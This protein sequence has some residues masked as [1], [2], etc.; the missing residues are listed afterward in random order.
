MVKIKL[1]MLFS[2]LLIMQTVVSGTFRYKPPNNGS[3]KFVYCINSFKKGTLKDSITN[4]GL[5]ALISQ[6]RNTVL[7]KY[8]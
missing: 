2:R 1:Y 7:N 6:K 4:L 3:Q 5:V 8:D